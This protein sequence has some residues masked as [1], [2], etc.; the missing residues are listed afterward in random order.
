WERAWRA[1]S[2][3]HPALGFGFDFD[4]L[5][6]SVEGVPDVG[7]DAVLAHPAGAD[8]DQASVVPVAVAQDNG[9]ASGGAGTALNAKRGC[10]GFGAFHLG[11]LPVARIHSRR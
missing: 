5:A 11:L 9:V 3:G 1:G 8:V 10:Y 4:E 2:S 6:G 7:L